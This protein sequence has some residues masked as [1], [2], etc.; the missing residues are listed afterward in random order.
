MTRGKRQ[1]SPSHTQHTHTHTHT[2]RTHTCTHSSWPT[3][4]NDNSCVHC[5]VPLF[6]FDFGRWVKSLCLQPSL[7]FYEQSK[8]PE[9]FSKTHTHTHMQTNSFTWTIDKRA[10]T[11]FHTASRSPS[12]QWFAL[13]LG[14]RVPEGCR[15]NGVSQTHS[16]SE[17]HHLTRT[18]SQH[19]KSQKPFPVRPCL[20]RLHRFCDNGGKSGVKSSSKSLRESFN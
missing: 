15:A 1:R 10:H 8:A 14:P 18:L 6:N 4:Y 19:R 20:S 11:H 9:T 16:A 5:D 3:H 2:H 13:P 17:T 7:G 12:P